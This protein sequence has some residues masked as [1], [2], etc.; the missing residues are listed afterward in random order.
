MRPSDF[1]STQFGA[2]TTKPLSAWP[3]AYFLPAPLPR[4]LVLEPETVAALSRADVA[5]GRL[6]GLAMV[7]DNPALLLGPAL[8]QEALASSRIEGTE[9]SLSEVLSAENED[10]PIENEN[11][12]EVANYLRA[13]GLSVGLLLNFGPRA[14]IR[15]VTRSSPK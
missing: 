1:I 12:R 8:A 11:L 9:A 15:R 7:I 3:H 13:S 14:S 5:L 2:L 4:E 10:V 6:S